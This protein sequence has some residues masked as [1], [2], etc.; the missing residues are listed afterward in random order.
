VEGFIGAYPNMFF[1]LTESQL[2]AFTLAIQ[3][4]NNPDDYTLLV[5]KYGVRR[6]A[7]WFWKLSD[8]FYANYQERRP[9]EAGLFDLNRYQN[10]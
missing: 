7:P 1:Q 2:Q 10:R 9:L 6:T 4:M 8:E 5:E 3:A